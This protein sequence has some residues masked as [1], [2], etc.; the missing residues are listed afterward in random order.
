VLV[1]VSYGHLIGR[2]CFQ[3]ATDARDGLHSDCG[4][5]Q[6]VLVSRR[7][8]RE[9]RSSASI[10]SSHHTWGGVSDGD[11]MANVACQEVDR[12]EHC[13]EHSLYTL[14]ILLTI[15]RMS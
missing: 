3:Q 4:L 10:S 12:T 14:Y 5:S 13:D 9:R 6:R 15:R 7:L 1:V 11:M 8:G 2:T